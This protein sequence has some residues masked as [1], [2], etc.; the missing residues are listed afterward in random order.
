MP[1]S[2]Y[3][4]WC[5]VSYFYEEL[6]NREHE[7]IEKMCNRE[8]LKKDPDEAIDYLNELA[9]KAYTWTG[10]SATNSTNRSRQPESRILGKKAALKHN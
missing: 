10:P 4:N 3:K 8:F 7:F 2:W 9:K 6:T 1:T 5:L